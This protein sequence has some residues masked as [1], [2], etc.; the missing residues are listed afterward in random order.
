MTEGVP[1]YDGQFALWPLTCGLNNC[2]RDA[3]CG[4]KQGVLHI[5]V[6]PEH[7]QAMTGRPWTPEEAKALARKEPNATRND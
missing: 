7:F 4:L 3:V 2:G 6:C 5:N 1:T